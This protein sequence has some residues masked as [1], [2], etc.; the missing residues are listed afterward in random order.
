MPVGRTGIKLLSFLIVLLSGQLVLSYVVQSAA[1]EEKMGSHGPSILI[2]GAGISG[3]GAADKLYQ[4]GFHNIRILE[5][6]GRTG[7]R[8]WTQKFAK[9]LAEIGA[10]WIHGPS[11]ENPIFELASH[12]NLLRPDA[13][14]EENQ[15]RD[16]KD[17]LSSIPYIIYSSSGKK[18]N[19][20]VFMNVTDM[21]YESYERAT[22]F[23]KDNCS[24]DASVGRFLREEIMRISQEW[25]ETMAGSYLAYLNGLISAELSDDGVHTLD[26]LALCPYGEYIPLPGRDCTF[27]KGFESLVNR[28][29]ENLPEDIVILNKVV[30]TVK[31]NGS[32]QDRDANVCPVEVQCE[33][34]DTFVADHVI[35]TVPLG[36]LKKRAEDLFSPSL[37]ASKL[38]AIKSLGFGTN[39]KIMLELE[40]PFWEANISFIQLI[41]EGTSP[42]A[43]PEKDLQKNWMKKLSGFVILEPPA[44]LGHVLCGF[45]PGE[46]SEYM[47]TLSDEEVLS[48]MTTLLRQFTGN[49]DLPPPISILR[50]KWHSHP[51]TIGSYSH[52]AVGSSGIDIDNLAEP[53]PED[54]DASKPLQVLFAGEAT[55]RRFHSTTHGALMSGR[56]EAQ[57]LI[58]RYPHIA[59]AV[60]KAKM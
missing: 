44:Q 50:T 11:P 40:E 56:R 3:I 48:T 43:E 28:I 60:T 22:N 7:G 57:R 58:D 14:L 5:A 54:K 23:T 39:N 15:K 9:G 29:K 6:T 17:Y 13:L 41:W 1:Q 31:W 52:V 55:E 53:L 21:F 49:P 30:K 16:R 35:V 34:G 25:E 12:Y 38:H 45:I 36:F 59:A 27:P 24:S 46:E 4:N 19:P 47:E 26:N 10:Q 33:D 20:E 2:I 37:P 18:I 32:F 8:I 51:Y 42:L